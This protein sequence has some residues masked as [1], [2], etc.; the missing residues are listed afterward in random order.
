MSP[1]PALRSLAA[2][3][4]T[5]WRELGSILASRRLHASLHPELGTSL[6]PSKLRALELLAEHD[7]LRVGEL[8]DRV[9]V[10]DTTATRL[11]DR[12]EQLGLAERHSEE[13]DRRAILVGLT[14][15]GRE[16]V[17]GV[18]AQRQQFF[19]DVLATLDDDERV[20][21]VRL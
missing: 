19:A 16:L 3:L 12:L 2:E 21:L 13:S 4:S 15:E 7:G 6:T 14:A 9:G 1:R 17:A 10:D 11:V 18:S 8:A 5:C 20:Q